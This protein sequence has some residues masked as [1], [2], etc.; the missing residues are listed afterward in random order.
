[1]TASTEILGSSSNKDTKVLPTV[2]ATEE[3]AHIVDSDISGNFKFPFFDNAQDLDLSKSYQSNKA[4][5]NFSP[6]MKHKAFSDN[7]M[8]GLG[9]EDSTK[10]VF[11]P[12]AFGAMTLSPIATNRESDSSVLYVEQAGEYL[13]MKP[14]DRKGNE[15]KGASLVMGDDLESARKQVGES[16]NKFID[17]IRN[18]AH[19]R[20]VAVA[21]SRDSLVAKEQEQLRSIAEFKAIKENRNNAENTRATEIQ[22]KP[23]GFRKSL[24]STKKI[25]FS[26]L[27]VPKVEKRPATT[28]FSPLLGSRRKVKVP[29]KALEAPFPAIVPPRNI[30]Q[31]SRHRSKQQKMRQTSASPKTEKDSTNT[32]KGFKARPMP[33]STGIRG[34]AGQMGVPKVSKRPTT[35][36]VSPGLGR[37]RESLKKDCR[38]KRGT[39][40]KLS[41]RSASLGLDECRQSA[42]SN[43]SLGSRSSTPSNGENSGLL[44]LNFLRSS[45]PNS[46][47]HDTNRRSSST[48][49]LI[50]K[51]APFEP[52]S[53]KRAMKRSLYDSACDEN[54][55][56]KLQ[57]ERE[58]LEER[59]RE[60]QKE[61]LL[62]G[63]KI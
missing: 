32:T 53:T 51:S 19:K 50:S 34:R 35:I 38:E 33:S 41:F 62:L 40:L 10:N 4:N 1:M 49:R 60:M 24:K 26:G 39:K 5:S 18:A 47:F 21:R 23:P 28:P 43:T 59:I 15:M 57:E 55:K 29:V 44:G 20:K 42:S 61:L 36:P 3:D 37:R 63:R 27:G 17:R 45:T 12:H 16:S 56:I 2:T 25:T 52:C 22:S 48:P 14:Q 54:R 31:L 9:V 58:R 46:H 6:S 7:E 8:D 13:D 11:S 30:G